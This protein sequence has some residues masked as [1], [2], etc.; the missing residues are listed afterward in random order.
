MRQPL[1]KIRQTHV[2]VFQQ[3]DPSSSGLQPPLSSGL[4]DQIVASNLYPKDPLHLH[5][6]LIRTRT[7]GGQSPL[8]L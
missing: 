6:I 8:K 3:E 7:A 2:L 5:L 1:G 4:K